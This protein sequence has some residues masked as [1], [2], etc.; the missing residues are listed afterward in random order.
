[1]VS[2]DVGWNS[3]TGIYFLVTKTTEVNLEYHVKSLDKGLP[4]DYRRLYPNGD[5]IFQQSEATSP[6]SHATQSYLIDSTPSFIKKD[7]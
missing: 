5:Y 6:I 4:P 7:E 2:A 3:G 1:M